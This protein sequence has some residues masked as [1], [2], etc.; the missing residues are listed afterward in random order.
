M[1]EFGKQLSSSRDD[2]PSD[3][4]EYYVDY[5]QLKS[6][7]K[8]AAK[9]KKEK[10]AQ[11]RIY[12]KNNIGSSKM[13]GAAAATQSS[14]GH[15]KKTSSYGDI[16][17]LMSAEEERGT[18]RPG[19]FGA[20]GRYETSSSFPSLPTV[21]H[22]QVFRRM[23][24]FRRHS[25]REWDTMA[26]YGYV[27][28]L[29]FRH[30]LD[31]QIE[32]LVLF[33]LT[34]EGLL[35]H[36]LY[37]LSKQRIR[38]K[39]QQVFRCILQFQTP[40]DQSSQSQLQS[41]SGLPSTVSSCLETLRT[42]TTDYRN[43]AEELLQLLKFT[44]L[45]IQAVRK[46]LKKHDKN[47]PRF[48][49]S[50]RYLHVTSIQHTTQHTQ[51][52]QEQETD[53]ESKEDVLQTHI[54]QL[55]HFGGLSALIYTLQNSF[56]ELH[57][58]ELMIRTIQQLHVQQQDQHGNL[59][60]KSYGTIF[61]SYHQSPV[62]PHAKTPV[63]TNRK[64]SSELLSPPLFTTSSGRQSQAITG[65]IGDQ[66]AHDTRTLITCTKENVMDEIYAARERLRET[67]QY[68]QYVAAQALV[69]DDTE[70]QF[71]DSSKTPVSRFTATQK[72]SSLLNLASCFLYMTNYYVVVPTVGI[73]WVLFALDA[74]TVSH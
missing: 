74:E 48:K 30:V 23:K 20:G 11:D 32:K 50:G 37:D 68:A 36:Q 15:R 25:H 1:V 35:A 58:M 42:L 51:E 16:L 41:A 45:N 28:M 66:T 18:N 2:F 9:K 5:S 47:F 21:L 14:R 7:I 49:L 6:I 10:D 54:N 40:H 60:T 22:E 63:L 19:V 13:T 57:K 34:Q 12:D 73:D 33:N 31:Q 61:D 4:E 53:G 56:D 26:K 72:L 38:F 62:K 29:E 67:T 3:W 8:D 59:R 55:Y 71:P 64:D 52:R 27:P 69:F 65:T 17:D 39:E 43:F 70:E 24:S 44:E 46:I